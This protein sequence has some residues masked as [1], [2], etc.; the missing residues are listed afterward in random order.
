VDYRPALRARTGAGA[1]VHQ[2]VQA[3]TARSA[4]EVVVFS[5]S[6]KDRVAP[7]VA[8]N[9]KVRVVDRR[10]PVQLLNYLWHRHQW[11]PVETLAG[12]ADVVHAGHPLL[13]PSRSAA[14]VVTVHDLYFLSH[15]D[16]T[17][18][19]V[20][21]DYPGLVR[22]HAQRADAVVTSSNYTKANIVRLLGVDEA[23]VHLV[24]P[25]APTW[26]TLGR[27]PSL[28]RD[29][30]ILFLGTLEPRK[31]L[32]VVLDAYERLIGQG[33]AVPALVVAGGA[34]LDAQQWID[35]MSR[36]PLRPHVTYRGYV[37]ETE[38]EA[39]FRGARAVVLPSW[40]EG[41]GLPALEGMTAGI[42]VIVSNRGALP[43]VVGDAG[44]LASPEDA[45]A[46]AQAVDRI[47]HDD[48]WAQERAA[49]GLDRARA[50]QWRDAADALGGA[51]S[52]AVQRRRARG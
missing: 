15:P 14:Q 16:D 24:R 41:F 38:R 42:P 20:R 17:S 51:Y 28:P 35:R 5:S 3:Y 36:A 30:Y 29:G 11:P 49:A 10:V 4:D 50:F 21:R 44:V 32:G 12:P 46:W 45:D 43:E 48:A 1:Y 22:A 47:A 33:R 7:D 39:L 23:R 8:A 26:A 18:G 34:G 13:I 40:D 37:P 31:N 9:L 25:G 19:E 27:A 2:L 6:W 52:A